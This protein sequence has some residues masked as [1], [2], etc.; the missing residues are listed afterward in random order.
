MKTHV[1]IAHYQSVQWEHLHPGQMNMI[2]DRTTIFNL[3][4]FPKPA[5]H[6][7][8]RDCQKGKEKIMKDKVKIFKVVITSP[9][10]SREQR[11][12]AAPKDA[13]GYYRREVSPD[14]MT[15]TYRKVA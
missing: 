9:D 7:G 8:K 3:P 6:A 15:I 5:D 1:S 13:E 10:G 2:A 11:R 12:L 4:L 14:G